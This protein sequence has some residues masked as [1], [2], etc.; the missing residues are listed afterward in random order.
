MF[1]KKREKRRHFR[2]IGSP[3]S[4]KSDFLNGRGYRGKGSL[5]GR[6]R[7]IGL[8]QFGGEHR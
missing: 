8:A 2:S 1:L 3:L 5:L 7:G 6:G 4:T